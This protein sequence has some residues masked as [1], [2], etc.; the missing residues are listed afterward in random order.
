MFTEGA[1]REEAGLEDEMDASFYLG[2]PRRF[3][4][5]CRPCQGVMYENTVYFIHVMTAIRFRKVDPPFCK[6]PENKSGSSI[7]CRGGMH[8][9]MPYKIKVIPQNTR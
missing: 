5:A 7:G 2:E 8:D 1:E 9:K 3:L 6:W 4:Q